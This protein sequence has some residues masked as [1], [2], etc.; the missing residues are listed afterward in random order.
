MLPQRSEK[1]FRKYTIIP[2]G[3]LKTATFWIDKNDIINL[4]KGSVLRLMDLF[5]V[6]FKNICGNF[7]EASFNSESY[8]EARKSKSKFIHWISQGEEIPCIVVMPN[9]KLNE[10]I[11]ESACKNLKPDTIIQF[12]RFGFVRVH[13]NDKKL[14]VYYSHK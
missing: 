10:G 11:A 13:H 6:E 3:N 5:N 14:V 2:K 8:S 9:A 7:A 4:S 12:E 1:G